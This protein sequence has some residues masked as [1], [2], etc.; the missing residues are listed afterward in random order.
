MWRSMKQNLMQPVPYTKDYLQAT[1]WASLKTSAG[2][3][4]KEETEPV[5]KNKGQFDQGLETSDKMLDDYYTKVR[6]VQ[7]Q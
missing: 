6:V 5:S 1:S 3:G 7:Y 4:V 2:R